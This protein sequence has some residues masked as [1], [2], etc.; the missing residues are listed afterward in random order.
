MRDNKQWAK[1]IIQDISKAC[2]QEGVSTKLLVE[3]ELGLA[4][5]LAV[6]PALPV[7][8]LWALLSGYPFP[9]LEQYRADAQK[10]QI[11][12]VARHFLPFYYNPYPWK[13]AIRFYRSVE[14][15]LRGYDINGE[16]VVQRPVTVGSR[17]FDVYA[18]VLASVPKYAR[19]PAKWATAGAYIF[20]TQR[21]NRSVTI[22][23]TLVFE[24][25]IARH[26][27]Q[28]RRTN[29]AIKVSW[30]EL[31]DAAREMDRLWP[32]QPAH[33]EDRLKRVELELFDERRT[34]L[35]RAN[36]LTI[37][38]IMHWIGMVSSGKSTLMEVLAYLLAGRGY[39]VTLIVGDV[40]GA[41]DRADMYVRLGIPAAPIL[42]TSNRDKHTNRLH[43][44]V[45]ARAGQPSL[46]LDHH[47][48]DWLST[49]CALDGVREENKPL[50]LEDYPCFSLWPADSDGQADNVTWEKHICPVY[51]RCPVHRAQRDLVGAR[52]WLATSASLIH[53]VPPSPLAPEQIRFLELVYH[54]SDI[55]IVD[56]ADVVQVQIDNAFSPSET[57]VNK[58]RDAWLNRL[59]EQVSNRLSMEGRAQL[60]DDRVARWNRAHE[61][62]Q[63]AANSVYTLLLQNGDLARKVERNYFT[64]WLFFDELARVFSGTGEGT[65]GYEELMACFKAFISDPFGDRAKNQMAALGDLIRIAQQLF[66]RN[67]LSLNRR[68]LE[69]WVKR[70]TPYTEQDPRKRELSFLL[71]ELAIVVALLSSQLDIVMRDWANA[72]QAFQLDRGGATLFQS[73]PE[74]Y[75]PL[76]P[77]SPM[78]NT[79]AYQYL[80]RS[81]DPEDA[82]QLRFFRCTG[83]GRWLLLHLHDLYQDEGSAGPHVILLSGTSWAGA[84]PA[85]HL[86][87]P[88]SGIL[89]APAHE[90]RAIAEESIFEF[91]PLR[92][93]N[94]S[95]IISVSGKRGDARYEALEQLVQ[96]LVAQRKGVNST[97]K[98]LLE[99]SR[100]ELP[101][102]RGRVMLLVGSYLEAAFVRDCILR[103]RPDW[104]G[105]VQSLVPDGDYEADWAMGSPTIQRGMVSQFAQTGAWILVAPLLAVERGHNILNEDDK[106]AIGAVYFL[107]RPHPRPD[108]IGFAIH[109]INRWAV[110]QYQNLEFNCYPDTGKFLPVN[111]AAQAF[112]NRAFGQWRSLLRMPLRYS[113]LRSDVQDAVTWTQLVSIW[114]VIGRLV[115]GGSPARVFF[116]DGAFLRMTDGE[117][118]NPIGSL[119]VEMRSVLR[120][121]FDEQSAISVDDR[122]IVQT[123][124][125]PL[126]AALQHSRGVPNH[127]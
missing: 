6:D 104:H 77:I 5:I 67:N 122:L 86:Q 25:P 11:L 36:R 118:P 126:Y 125:G 95:E 115:R 3:I 70:Y 13:K 69:N 62:V 71:F 10:L 66:T 51:S 105:Q 29:P 73:M 117:D 103:L 89:R 124:Y 55:V 65:G 61:K 92:L 101:E 27:L 107:V 28:K 116:C 17:R 82:G 113:T 9:A 127:V 84:S 76:I 78:G 85:Y 100:D 97:L 99:R 93:P 108:D 34:A 80:R 47:G 120:P 64:P 31:L 98:S 20:G 26:Q 53:S 46:L 68:S 81:G 33:W 37:Q 109:S 45:S 57:L 106:A 110:E 23:D 41:L 43:Q 83:V 87:I 40:I 19:R 21:G 94:G 52:I 35:R 74:D 4:T 8:S 15:R 2:A 121:Y 60:K 114:Q 14:G 18:A 7:E 112:R 50:A 123:L 49:A 79:L 91:K 39:H 56:E 102:G 90:V 44:V 1:S 59:G 88:V 75:A 16:Q 12:R 22:P 30:E 119:L 42:G 38:A 48:F 63:T 54:H 24:P 58:G 96:A 72:E 111:R 32:G